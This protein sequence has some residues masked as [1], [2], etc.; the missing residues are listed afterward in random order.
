MSKLERIYHENG[1]LADVAISDVE[2]FR[3]ERIANGTFWITLHIAGDKHIAFSLT[4]V[5]NTIVGKH[6]QDSEWK[7]PN[8]K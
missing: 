7:E 1:D 5:E 6:E 4:A 2:L 8:K 3:M